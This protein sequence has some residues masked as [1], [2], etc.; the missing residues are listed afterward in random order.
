MNYNYISDIIEGAS[1][2]NAM[3]CELTT[4]IDSLPGCKS[5]ANVKQL[6]DEIRLY[7]DEVYSIVQSIAE[8]AAM[9]CEECACNACTDWEDDCDSDIDYPC[10]TIPADV[11]D[12]MTKLAAIMASDKPV[13]VFVDVYINEDNDKVEESEV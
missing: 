2:L 5:T 7:S 10:D 3:L 13:T 11:N 8:D 1:L 6:S 9:A 12:F 4:E